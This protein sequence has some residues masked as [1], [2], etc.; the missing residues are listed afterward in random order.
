M[1]VEHLRLANDLLPLS[2]FEE[3]QLLLVKFALLAVTFTIFIFV[4][5]DVFSHYKYSQHLVLEHEDK[6][7]ALEDAQMMQNQINMQQQAFKPGMKKQE[8]LA[9]ILK[10]Q[11]Q[12]D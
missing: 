9:P 2:H 1:P 6:I 10:D 7:I 12:H 11:L 5:L 3:W 8:A 4:A